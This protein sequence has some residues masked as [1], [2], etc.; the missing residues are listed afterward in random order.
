[1]HDPQVTISGAGPATRPLGALY[2]HL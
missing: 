1:M 2:P